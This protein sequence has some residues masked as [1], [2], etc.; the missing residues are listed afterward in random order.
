[1]RKT[2]YVMCVAS[3]KTSTLLVF[4]RRKTRA[5]SQQLMMAVLKHT[6]EVNLWV[7]V[8]VFAANMCE[9]HKAAS[10]AD[11]HVGVCR[12][13][14]YASNVELCCLTIHEP[15]GESSLRE[16]KAKHCDTQVANEM[17]GLRSV[18][19]TK[20]SKNMRLPIHH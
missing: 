1:M 19:R 3:N 4:G 7:W 2:V 12:P 15:F 8:V 18:E 11:M 17:N 13:I 14:I 6:F 5:A 10:F 20:V 16:M 9:E